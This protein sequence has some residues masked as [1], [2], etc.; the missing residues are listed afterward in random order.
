MTRTEFA[1]WCQ[2]RPRLLDGATGSNLLR[3]GMPRGVCGEAWILEHPEPL[4]QL[5]EAYLAA[6]SEV[7]YAPTF[8]AN[9]A[10]LGLHGLENEVGRLNR[11]L[12]GLSRG[13]ARGR[14]LVAGD[15]TTTGRPVEPYGD[16]PYSELLDLY[17][18]QAQ[19]LLEGGVDLFAVETMMG[20]TECMAAV[21]AIR[22]LCE[23]PILVTM[24]LQSDGKAY[25]DGTGEEAAQVLEA[26][27][28][29]AVGVNCSVG[30]DQLESVVASIRRACSL[31]V[32]A[33]PNAGLPVILETGEAVYAMGPADFARH[34]EKLHAAGAGLLGG[35]CG[36][37]P[38]HIRA[39]RRSLDAGSI[40]L[41]G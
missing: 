14:A 15:L 11:A 24:S 5:Q 32:A 1:A 6:G 12:A 29:D 40:G 13:V 18:E 7:L 4:V 21:E 25:F 8:G 27:G 3:A 2:E 17:Q 34:M 19:A 38:E 35:C 23:L 22:G 26:L 36:T 10:A 33:K 41:H 28:A 20:V 31:P 39:L 37:T 16:F 30:P 9:R